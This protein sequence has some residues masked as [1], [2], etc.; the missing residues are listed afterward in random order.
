MFREDIMDYR[1]M[2]F[3]VQGSA[4]SGMYYQ[5]W[6]DGETKDLEQLKEMYP[7]TTRRIQEIIDEECDRHEFE[8]SIL[9]DQYPDKVAVSF[10]VNRIHDRLKMEIESAET[11]SNF[12]EE[13]WLKDIITIMLLTEMYRRRAIRRNHRRRYF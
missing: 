1:Y 9:Y 3:Y 8:G 4:L 12:P 10:I 2:P 5:P 11:N 6:S 13:A 7:K